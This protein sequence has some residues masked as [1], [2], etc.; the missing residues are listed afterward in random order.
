MSS[1]SVLKESTHFMQSFTYDMTQR[2]ADI[3]IFSGGYIYIY[4]NTVHSLNAYLLSQIM[5]GF[6]PL[7]LFKPLLLLYPLGKA[8]IIKCTIFQ[9]IVEPLKYLQYRINMLSWT[10]I[11]FLLSEILTEI[12]LYYPDT[13]LV[14]KNQ[15]VYLWPSNIHCKTFSFKSTLHFCIHWNRKKMKSY[16]VQLTFFLL[17]NICGLILLVEYEYT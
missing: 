8:V 4:R 15:A 1:L 7:L 17:W 9:K 3:C 6:R 10:N 11:P 13:K 16:L 2:Y 12:L 5:S 14:E